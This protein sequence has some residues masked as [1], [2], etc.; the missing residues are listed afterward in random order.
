MTKKKR[1]TTH[2][3]TR[4]PGLAESEARLGRIKDFDHKP[5]QADCVIELDLM[6]GD[7]A[8]A[9]GRL[10]LVMK[11]DEPERTFTETFAETGKCYVCIPYAWWL[12]NYSNLTDKGWKLY[13]TQAG[14]VVQ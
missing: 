5:Q 8:S 2:I 3:F 1:N 11:L 14:G 12:K 6:E 13:H 7:C 9:I 10:E 4:T